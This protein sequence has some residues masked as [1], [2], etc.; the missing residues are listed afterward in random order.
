MAAGMRTVERT[1]QVGDGREAAL[2]DHVLA[3][4]TAG[5]P[6]SVLAAI[7]DFARNHSILMNVGD[8]KGEIL[9]AAIGRTQP[10]LLLE[11]G[12]YCGYSAVRTGRVMPPGARLVSVEAN[13]ANADIARA[14]IA[15]A[16][17][18]DRVA[19]VVGKIGDGGRTVRTLTDEHGFTP[20]SVDFLFIDHLKSAY[21]TDLRTILDAGWLHP[22]S[23]VVAD[24]VKVPGA[25]DYLRYMRDSEG[26]T[27][28][29][30][31]HST[32][33]EYQSL[34]KDLVLESEYLG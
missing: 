1:G 31:E 29:T 5:D 26:K 14:V 12:A 15:H 11:L 22:G 2:R 7:D 34:V 27:W 13:P 24:N 4:A 19:V 23:V 17:L 3:H 32:H 6:G 16:G 8:E 25:P 9:D 21:L 18:A 28:R 30:I 10:K 20:G 33:L